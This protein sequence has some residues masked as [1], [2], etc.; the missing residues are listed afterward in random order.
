MMKR[1]SFFGRKEIGRIQKYQQFLMAFFLSFPFSKQ[2]FSIDE[3]R[4]SKENTLDYLQFNVRRLRVKRRGE[5]G[6]FILVNV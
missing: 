1:L 2:Q 5:G 6:M 4:K 3:R